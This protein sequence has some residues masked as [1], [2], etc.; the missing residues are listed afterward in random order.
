L[1]P[2]SLSIEHRASFPPQILFSFLFPFF[3]A[4]AFIP[5]TFD[6]AKSAIFLR[7][8]KE[9]SEKLKKGALSGE[10]IFFG[11]SAW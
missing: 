5:S 11:N 6:H 3:T 7:H 10:Y 1:P 8:F 2:R 9:I 4:L